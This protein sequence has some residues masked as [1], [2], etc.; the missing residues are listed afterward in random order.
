MKCNDFMFNQQH[1]ELCNL[2]VC[3]GMQAYIYTF[4]NLFSSSFA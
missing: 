1:D 4:V 2:L 3:K